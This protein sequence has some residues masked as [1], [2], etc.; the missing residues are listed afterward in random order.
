MRSGLIAS[1]MVEATAELPP[2][3]LVPYIAVAAHKVLEGGQY[4]ELDERLKDAVEDAR[5]QLEAESASMA[6][7]GRTPGAHAS[8]ALAGGTRNGLELATLALQTSP[9]PEHRSP[10]AQPMSAQ[11]QL[12]RSS[13]RLQEFVSYLEGLR[14]G[15]TS[16]A[17]K[18]LPWCTEM[19]E[20]L[21]PGSGHIAVS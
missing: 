1:E 9:S 21:F 12:A 2:Y 11:D 8:S 20:R 10:T 3:L 5:E 17:E 14:Q 7:E 13:S 4:E 16:A 6:G 18:L 15:K 19:S